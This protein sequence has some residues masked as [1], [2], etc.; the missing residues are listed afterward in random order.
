[1][2]FVLG[3][4]SEANLVDVRPKLVCCVRYAIKRTPQDFG[5]H[6]GL[7]SLERQK[8]LFAAG[9]SRTLDSYHLD[10]HAVDL[11]PYIDGRLQW[12]VGP[13]LAVAHV[14]LQ[15]SRDLAVRLVW[16]AVWDRELGALDPADLDGEVEA[17]VRRY[18]Q[19]HPGKKPL[20]DYPHFQ[21]VRG[22]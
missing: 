2:T 7:R 21:L 16:G 15:A 10:G 14:M 11:V 18:K 6:E 19:A 4:A 22:Q 3:K 9:A 13:C 17:Y 8:K 20:I 12:Q 5:V 1:M